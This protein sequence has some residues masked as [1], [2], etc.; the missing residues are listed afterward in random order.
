MNHVE[1]SIKS[2]QSQILI[3]KITIFTYQ[4]QVDKSDERHC[5]PFFIQS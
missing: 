2:D 3:D 5:D 4:H 1:F